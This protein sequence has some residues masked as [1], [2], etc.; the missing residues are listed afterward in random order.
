MSPPPI[1]I[2]KIG[3]SL[4][5]LPDFAQRLT[6]LISKFP[7]CHPLLII[8]G[9]Q[10][11][12]VVRNWNDVHQLG[13]EIAHQLAIQSLALNEA[14]LLKLLPQL[15]HVKNIKEAEHVWKERGVP[16]L[17][18]RHF[19]EEYEPVSVVTLPHTWDVT[20]DSIAAW[21]AFEWG[22][23]ELVLV[24]SIDEPE[25]FEE[26]RDAVDSYFSEMLPYLN[27]YSWINLRRI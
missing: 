3:G 27:D 5:L 16:L 26:N 2:Y 6:K 8:G 7:Y 14:L 18:T 10:T 9:G 24:K 19:I 4:L 23:V 13:D 12:D 11:T 25:N 20:S 15:K 17:S 22:A 1:I 21:V